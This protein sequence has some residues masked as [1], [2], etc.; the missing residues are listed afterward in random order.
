LNT[1]IDEGA[2]IGTISFKVTGQTVPV[3][4]SQNVPSPTWD[5]RL[6]HVF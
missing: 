1:P 5:W 6:T 3:T 2:Q 4:V